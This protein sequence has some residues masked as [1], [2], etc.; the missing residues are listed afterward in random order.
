MAWHLT[1]AHRHSCLPPPPALTGPQPPG[2][3][4]RGIRSSDCGGPGYSRQP[5]LALLAHW[6]AVAAGRS[7]HSDWGTRPQ[8]RGGWDRGRSL[9]GAVFFFFPPLNSEHTE[10]SVLA[11]VQ[12]W[13]QETCE[14][15]VGRRRRRGGGPSVPT[16]PLISNYCPRLRFVLM[17]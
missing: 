14:E 4:Q 5:N 12:K 16:H 8:A 1:R 13:L 9:F 7:S 17:K 10:H 3:K 2:W 6:P 15:G 11:A